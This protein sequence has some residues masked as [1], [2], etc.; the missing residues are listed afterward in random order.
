M[1]ND[2]SKIKCVENIWVKQFSITQKYLIKSF[3]Y[4]GLAHGNSSVDNTILKFAYFVATYARED[5]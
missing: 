5:H 2:A 3:A 1:Y 4:S